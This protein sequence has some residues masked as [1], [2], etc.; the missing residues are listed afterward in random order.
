MEFEFKE[1]QAISDDIQ[2][3]YTYSN[4]GEFARGI[5]KVFEK[6]CGRAYNSLIYDNFS[7]S[8]ANGDSLDLWGNI[9]G[10]SR[11]IPSDPI[12]KD[13]NYF[14]FNNKQFVQLIFNNPLSPEYGTIDDTGFRELLLFLLQ[15]QYVFPS[16]FNL[17]E[18]LS[19]FFG[20][21]GGVY[22]ED[23]FDMSYQTVWFNETIPSW[24]SYKI[25]VN[26]ILPRPAGVGSKFGISYNRFFGF[27]TDDDEFNEKYVGNFYGCN[28]I[29][30]N[31]LKRD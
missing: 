16:P 9:L 19:S 26:D 13:Y 12:G 4:V 21:Y 30:F 22:I 6:H 10:L 25:S 24:L 29:D 20:K 14:N 11:Y 17:N 8:T 18:F 23:S 3:Q 7:L 15:R 27:E 28:F 31:E 5:L 2:G 1:Y